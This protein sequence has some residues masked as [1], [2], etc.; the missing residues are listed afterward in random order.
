MSAPPSAR[1]LSLVWTSNTGGTQALV[2]AAY[3][4][5]LEAIRE[6]EAAVIVASRRCDQA[7][8]AFLETADVL[9]L[10]CPE[11]LGSVAGPMKTFL[12]QCYYPLLGR[13]EGR[14]WSAL[15]C[16]GT[17]GE[18]ALR[19]LRRVA[20]GWGMRETVPAVLV[21]SGDQSPEQI[22]GPT[23]LKPSDLAQA[24]E[25]GGTLAAGLAVGLW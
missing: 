2:E 16:A 7:D 12:D 25:L 23:R 17:D 4:G 1:R 14:A 8:A 6:T 15:I 19:L 20:T 22:L 11:C 9:I 3:R 21:R 24:H 5:A 10:A 13:L 18:G